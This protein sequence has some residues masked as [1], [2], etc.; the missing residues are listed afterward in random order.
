MENIFLQPLLLGRF[1]VP[2]WLRPLL[3]A[4]DR[5][6]YSPWYILLI[7]CMAIIA[8]TYSLELQ[9]YTAYTAMYICICLLGRD[10]LPVMPMLISCYLI[11]STQNNPG[12]NPD[13]IFAFGNGGEH[14]LL[15][16]AIIIIFLLLRL[17]FDKHNGFVSIP[18][19]KFTLLSGILILGIAYMIS[20]I[21]SDGYLQLAQKNIFFG[22]LQF[23]ALIV[24]YFVFSFA[25]DWKNA[26]ADYL[27]H[28][29][30]G[31]GFLLLA[32]LVKAYL[33]QEDV[34]LS[35]IIQRHL[36]YTGWGM[37]NNIGGML[38]MMLPFPFFFSCKYKFSWPGMIIGTLFMI[39]IVF[40]SSR[41]SIL[42]GAIIYLICIILVLILS[43]DKIGTVSGL[44][45]IIGCLAALIFIYHTDLVKLLD[46]LVNHFLKQ[47]GREE[48]Y[49]HGIRQ[50]L[51]N[52]IFG[53]TF[54][55]TDYI[56]WDFSD[57]ESFSSFFPPRWHNT[58]IQ[59]LASCGIVGLAAY[60]F[61]RIQ[62]ICL[63]FRKPSI[64][65][66]FIGLSILALLLTSLLDCHF[67][68]IGPVLFY[69]M[70]LA[71]AENVNTGNLRG[72]YEKRS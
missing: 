64:E 24:P 53:V 47:T 69:S 48:I 6:V 2:K 71:F 30:V 38:A 51:K 49:P 70:A 19:K 58:I 21:G 61:H 55:P 16:A 23:A 41:G 35:G 15:L 26:P 1:A 60:S 7:I 39:G 45:V 17:S 4:A 52:P 42:V 18:K 5:F 63:L 43:K 72:K 62:T 13:S 34:I 46:F 50:F 28:I 22:F 54:Y 57:V 11:P 44:V 67:F 31:V 33:T 29:G 40:T 12:K 8:N 14:I 59:L 65:K 36:L 32:E 9:I 66:I 68:N 27:S 3:S 37:Y 56:P 25:V 20:G 10:L